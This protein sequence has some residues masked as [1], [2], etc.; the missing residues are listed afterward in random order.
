MDLEAAMSQ[1]DCSPILVNSITNCIWQIISRYDLDFF[2][3]L[4]QG[5]TEIGIAELI[6][7]LMRTH[8]QS[9]DIITTNY[10]RIIEYSCDV[11]Q[12]LIDNSCR[13]KY[14]QNLRISEQKE[15]GYVNLLKIHGSLDWFED[16]HGRVISIPLQK[17]IPDGLNPKIIVPGESKFKRI[18]LPPFRDMLGYMDALILNAR[19]YLCIGYGFNDM[20]I[21]ELILGKTERNT[22]IV[23]VTKWLPDAV[24]LSL[25]SR[26][27]NFAILQAD[28]NPNRTII[29]TNCGECVVDKNVWNIGEFAKIILQ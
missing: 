12:I 2:N 3:Q 20:Q 22:P 6:Q 1:L 18:L 28:S 9:L 19:S 14:L 23:I 13:G 11:S 5:K 26:A 25:Q 27:K 8:P 4:I 29:K 7:L 10:D 16:E 24:I 17:N 15:K 21:Q